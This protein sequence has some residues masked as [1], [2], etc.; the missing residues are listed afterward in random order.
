MKLAD[1]IKLAEEKIAAAKA[2]FSEAPQPTP[3]PQPAALSTYKLADG[4][5]V[6]IDKLEA[7]GI[8]TIGGQPAPAGELT[9]EDGTVIA[10][11][12]GGIISE[13]KAAAP[14]VDPAQMGQN[15]DEQFAGINAKF[16]QYEQHFTELKSSIALANNVINKQQEAIT[17]LFDVVK[18]LSEIP[19]GDPAQAPQGNFAAKAQSKADLLQSFSQ[20]LNNTKKEK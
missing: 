7:G 13:V 2:F 11:A 18:Q 6:S 12:E 16:E 10:V 4:T 1:A 5:E 17:Q 14:A 15:Y 19:S 20:S 9:L 8:V 3:E